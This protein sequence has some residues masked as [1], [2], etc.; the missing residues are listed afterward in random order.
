M[1]K[2]FKIAFYDFKR[3]LINPITFIVMIIVLIASLI[4]GLSY[5]LHPS[6][7]YLA[8]VKGETASEIYKNFTSSSS[9]GDSDINLITNISNAQTKITIQTQDC[10][11]YQT[12]TDIDTTL[13]KIKVE[14]NKMEDLTC[15]YVENNNIDEIL[16]VKNLMV[17]FVDNYKN[18]DQ[19]NSKLIFKTDSFKKLEETTKQF[20]EILS[21]GTISEKAQ[22]LYENIEIFDIIKDINFEVWNVDEEQLEYL[23]E[24]YIDKANAKLEKISVEMANLNIASKDG[25]PDNAKKMLSLATSYKLTAESAN[26]GVTGELMMMLSNH[27]GNLNK[28]YN[29]KKIQEEELTLA[30]VKAKHYISSQELY[31]TQSQEPLNFNHASYE[32]T[33]YD[34]AYFI[35]AIIGFLDVLFGIFCAYKLFGR[36]RKNG[37]MDVILSQNVTFG[38]VFIGKA[39]AIV[40]ITGFMLIAYSLVSLLFSL[41]LYPKLA[42]AILGVFNLST[43]YS[44]HPFGFLILKLITIELQVIFYSVITIFLM[45]ISRK[46]E[47]T[48]AIGILIFALA[49][50]CNI[51]FNG[52]LIYCLFPFIHADLSSMFAGTTMKGGFLVTSLYYYGNFFISLAYYLVVVVLLF[53]F[54]KQLFKKN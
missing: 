27:F 5:K 22:K 14:I 28:I 46:F 39:L 30:L 49:T 44:I 18:L 16:N 9:V 53:L 37:K 15:K 31:Y 45:N 4:T 3:L 33:A 1:R 21:D 43:A 19:F 35:I 11:D 13:S 8:D 42:G 32:V 7:Q 23:Q 2:I 38:Q 52:S 6:E 51:F 50:I 10:Q 34:H 40:L 26:F 12:L 29:Y 41:L 17:L 54:T 20:D 25:N 36:D 24:E 48:F 47:V